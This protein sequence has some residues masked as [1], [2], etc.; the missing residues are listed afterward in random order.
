MT[1][2][3]DNKILERLTEW[4][5]EKG[6]LPKV[7]EFY[8]RLLCIQSQAIVGVPKLGL[9]E[10]T[11]SNR[12]NCGTPLLEFDDLSIDWALVQDTFEEV[13]ALFA[14]YSE[15]LGK[16][17]D[18]LNKLSSCLVLKEVVKAWF[19][20]APLSPWIAV[21][22]VSEDLFEF[23]IRATIRPILTS[24]CEALLKF[25]NQEVWR[26]G[27]CPICGGSPNFAFLDKER[28]ARW[29]LCSRCDAEWLFQRLECPYCGTQNHS[30]LAYFTGDE[31]LYR[32]YVCEHCRCF[33]KAVDLRRAGREVLLPLERF[34]TLDIDHQAREKGYRPCSEARQG[35]AMKRQGVVTLLTKEED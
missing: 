33:L 11:I 5:E 26:R 30:A 13:T 29:L 1:I 20:G 25:V 22:G 21:G 31:G 34:L 19:E 35:E 15:V 24:H 17:P 16:T 4:E 2:G 27:Y 6:S 3:T 10:N 8:R 7:L 9:S 28:G 18:S 23:M 32:L 12:I 14:N